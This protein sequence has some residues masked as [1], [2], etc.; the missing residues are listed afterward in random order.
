MTRGP[1]QMILFLPHPPVECH[2]NARPH[3]AAKARATAAYRRAVGLIAANA[4]KGAPPPRYRLA[5]VQVIA[6]FRDARRRDKDNLLAMLKPAFDALA[7]AG[8]V[9]DDRDFE[10]APVIVRRDRERPGI[11]L[12]IIEVAAARRDGGTP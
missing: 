1:R 7:D 11:T 5:R 4:R 10:Y 8:V 2:P 12:V 3:W 6:K 9:R